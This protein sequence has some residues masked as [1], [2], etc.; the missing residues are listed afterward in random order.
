MNWLPL[1]NSVVYSVLGLVVFCV[2]FVVIDTL[3]PYNLWQEIVKDKNIALAIVI[4]CVSIGLC[5]II[6]SAIHG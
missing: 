4:G 3:T 5:L 1:L 2:G 6:A